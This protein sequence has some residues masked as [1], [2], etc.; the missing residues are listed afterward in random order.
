[1][2]VAETG[3][4][5]AYQTVRSH[6]ASARHPEGHLGLPVL[7]VNLV[8][9]PHGAPLTP[10]GGRD[11][12]LIGAGDGIWREEEGQTLAASFVKTTYDCAKGTR[13]RS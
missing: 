1:M 10:E 3:D 8:L 4:G 6:P 12:H 7:E 11:P 13:G 9:G 5:P 2:F